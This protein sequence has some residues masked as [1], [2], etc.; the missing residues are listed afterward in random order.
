[1]ILKDA[2]VTEFKEMLYHS[3][4]P[5]CTNRIYWE[6]IFDADGSNY[7]AQCCDHNFHAIPTQYRINIETLLDD[8]YIDNQ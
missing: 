6:A 4:C 8:Y 3:Q 2:E 5:T 7:V 1:M